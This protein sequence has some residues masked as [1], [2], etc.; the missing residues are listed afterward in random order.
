[1]RVWGSTIGRSVHPYSVIDGGDIK[2]VW[3]EK[4]L[5]DKAT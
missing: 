4:D 3:I 1:M 2:R 5:P